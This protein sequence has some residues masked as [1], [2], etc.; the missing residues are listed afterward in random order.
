MNKEINDKIE[1]I[2]SEVNF[3]FQPLLWVDHEFNYIPMDIDKEFLYFENYFNEAFLLKIDRKHSIDRFIRYIYN[4]LGYRSFLTKLDGNEFVWKFDWSSLVE[5][6]FD[7]EFYDNT[8]FA[9]HRK[10]PITEEEVEEYMTD[11]VIDGFDE[12]TK[13]KVI[14]LLEHLKLKI[15]EFRNRV[16]LEILDSQS[17]DKAKSGLKEL[18]NENIKQYNNDFNGIIDVF[19]ALDG[20]LKWECVFRSE[21]D[22]EL[23]ADL[24]AKYFNKLPYTIPSKIIDN[25]IRSKT[26][27]SSAINEIYKL[28]RNTNSKMISDTEFFRI[29]KSLSVYK[30]LDNN[31]IYN[32]ITK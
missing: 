3:F 15:S 9:N 22:M 32:S 26:K 12:K 28:N 31:S 18:E 20:N 2:K 19:N 1:I 8:Y 27:L 25:Q 11:H 10:D 30:D 17:F 13:V 16:Y 14:E 24:L 23:I 6:T 29:L 7:G 21:D 5:Y 4:D